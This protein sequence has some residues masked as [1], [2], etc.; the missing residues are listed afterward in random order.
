MCCCCGGFWCVQRNNCSWGEVVGPV[1]VLGVG[2]VLFVECV[3]KILG[4]FLPHD[5]VGGGGGGDPRC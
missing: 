5:Q 3:G 1:L 2:S 4:G